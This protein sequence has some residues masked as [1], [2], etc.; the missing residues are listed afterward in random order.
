[1][2]E[3]ISVKERLPEE[4]EDVLAYLGEGKIEVCRLMHNMFWEASDVLYDLDAVT[5]W[6]ALPE[7][8][9]EEGE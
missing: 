9:K 6:M 1:M 2:N 3:W 5:H 4:G 7:P 8:P